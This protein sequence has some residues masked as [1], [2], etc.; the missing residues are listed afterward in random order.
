MHNRQ[1]GAAHVPMMLFVILMVLFLGAV[2]FAYVQTSKN[3]ELEGKVAALTNENA[4]DVG[5]IKIRDHYIEDIG[6]V[7]KLAGE[8]HGR[9]AAK[10]EYKGETL[11]GVPGVMDPAAVQAKMDAHAQ[12]M[13]V[14]SA[15]SLDGLFSSDV[16]ALEALKKSVTEANDAR[17]KIQG[18]KQAIDTSFKSAQTDHTKAEQDTKEQ[19]AQARQA[20][21]AQKAADKTTLDATNQSLREKTDE[22]SKVT[23]AAAAEKKHLLGEMGKLL[24]QNTA[25]QS[26]MALRNPPDVADGKVIVARNGMNTAFIDLGRKDNLMSG[27]VFQ[28]KNP[29]TEKDSDKVKAL[30]TVIKV[31]Q[32]RAEV[33]LTQVADPVGN[34]V[35]E[36]DEL[37]NE[38]YSPGEKRNIFLLGRFDYPVNKPELE[39][40]LTRLGNKVYAKMEPGVDLVILGNVIPNAELDGTTPITDMPEY[41][42]AVNL[43]VEMVPL[44]KIRDLIKP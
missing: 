1:S 15:K 11:A 36:G 5:K 3:N 2:A 28:V 35:R 14:A 9:P 8:Y 34:P 42:T 44:R 29:H 40:L 18:E 39:K 21:E 33:Q 10:E 27:T 43:G 20:F 6:G 32:E 25:L 7:I 41:K 19:L 38:L 13:G 24:G 16:A 12:A 22:V 26:K 31:E 37:F 30:A 17:D 4:Q 23:E